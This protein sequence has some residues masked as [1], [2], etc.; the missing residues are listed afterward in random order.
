MTRPSPL[1]SS[2][3]STPSWFLP[4]LGAVVVAILGFLPVVNWIRGGHEAAWYGMVASEWLN[5]SLIALG[6]GIVLAI[7][8][9][10]LPLWREGA[11]RELVVR[12]HERP[13]VTGGVLFAF[14]FAL[15]AAVALGVLS[16]KP[17]LIDELSQLF[18][19]RIF[20]Q[21]KL[22]LEAPQYPEFTSILHILDG[23]GKWFSQFPFGGPLMLVPGVW[24]GA[25]WLVGPFAGASSVAVFWAIVRRIEQRQAVA[26][27]A[28]LLFMVAP[29]VAFMAGSHMNH[30]TALTWLLVAI[31]GLVRQTEDGSPHPAFAALCGFSL[32]MLATIRPVDAVAFALPAGTWMLWRAIK[33]PPCWIE[34]VGAGLAIAGPA[35]A[36]LW[37]NALTTGH[38]LLFA[39]EELWGKDHGLGFHSAPWGF[40]HSPARGLE[41]LSLYFLR[42]QSYLF[43]TGIP[44]LTAAVAGLALARRLT[45]VDRYLFA[46]AGLLLG[47][48]FAYWHDGF[49][50]GPRFVYLLS[51]FFILWTARFPSLLR[52]R[53]PSA[54]V[55]HRVV[56]YS[57][58]VAAAMALTINLPFRTRQYAGGLASMRL[59]YIGVAERAGIR[60]ALILVRESWG[61]QL[62]ARLWALGVPHSQ[63][64]SL[65]RSVDACQLE[66]AVRV[67]EAEGVRGSVAFA[68]L[69]PLLKDSARVVK[70]ELSPDRTERMLPGS[71]YTP[72][73]QQRIIED[74]AGFTL[75]AP[76]L[77][78]SWG[79]NTYVRD[80]H[81]HNSLLISANVGR[82]VYLMRPVSNDI[83]AP[84]RLEPL[85]P[86]SLL[87]AWNATHDAGAAP[88]AGT[89]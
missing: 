34:V 16:G 39:Y 79:T 6:G 87:K 41:L 63:T 77:V 3:S 4:R 70:S 72:R 10:R 62:V 66:E 36:I 50:L 51:P 53:W 1:D 40:A 27:G 12:A 69:A 52:E 8:S 57:M 15:Y 49:Y 33:R 86:D 43:E 88:R 14:A 24:L 13:R 11:L 30:V 65:Y 58:A 19:A 38:P 47:L 17:L 89:R 5:G 67:L 46:S 59:D 42:L 64:E 80:L 32:G 23:R 83:G 85:R 26:L 9:R 22:W 74:R 56:W 78:A 31:Y 2:G 21:G 68:R 54:H 37:Y 35:G 18:Q 25:P 48:Y 71:L 61:T 44:S 7:L 55:A 81:E 73:C 20:A 45:A 76:V 84:L 28:S 82:P 75:L 60:D 29:F